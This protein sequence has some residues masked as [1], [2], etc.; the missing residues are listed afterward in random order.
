MMKSINSRFSGGIKAHPVHP[1]RLYPLACKS[2]QQMPAEYP[3]A[4]ARI[5]E[6]K[7]G[8][9]Q[10]RYGLRAY[11]ESSKGR[12]KGGVY[13]TKGAVSGR[14]TLNRRYTKQTGL[15]Y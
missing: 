12:E 7:G 9:N 10:F 8:G 13:L 3:A 2:D 15:F 4:S 14:V 6:K 1:V 11:R 5:T